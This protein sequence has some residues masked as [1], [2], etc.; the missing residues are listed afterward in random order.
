MRLISWGLFFILLAVFVALLGGVGGLEGRLVDVGKWFIG[1]GAFLAL[2]WA[3]LGT[4]G[5][6]AGPGPPF[7]Y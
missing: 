1:V 2:V 4:S 7:S 6:S 3:V 5:R